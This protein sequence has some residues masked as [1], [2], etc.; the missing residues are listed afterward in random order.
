MLVP[1][2][3]DRDAHAAGAMLALGVSL[4]NYF[5]AASGPPSPIAGAYPPHRDRGAAPRAALALPDRHAAIQALLRLVDHARQTA[6]EWLLDTWL[7][8]IERALDLEAEHGAYLEGMIAGHADRAAPAA[9]RRARSAGSCASRTTSRQDP[10]QYEPAAMLFA[11]CARAIEA[12]RRAARVVRRRG[13][14]R[15]AA[16]RSSTCTGSPRSRTRPASPHR[17][18]AS[19]TA[20]LAV[21]PPRRRLRRRVPRHRRGAPRRSARAAH[22]RAHAG[23]GRPRGIATPINGDAAFEA[24]L[25]AASEDRLDVAVAAPALGGRRR[26]RQR[27][28][29]AEPRRRARPRSAA[30]SRRSACSR[31][32]SAPTRR[33]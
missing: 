1:P 6:P 13:R 21:R 15:A 23:A 12:R 7:L 3:R 24:G 2:A 25:A 16:G 32:T 20:L 5:V 27:E 4:A 10:S 14:R 11:R 28:A 29:R 18:C 33:A 17:G 30:A 9:R 8:R 31:S 19:R 22:R 26:A